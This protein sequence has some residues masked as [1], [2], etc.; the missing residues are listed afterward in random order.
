VQPSQPDAQHSRYRGLSTQAQLAPEGLDSLPYNFVPG[1]PA[2]SIA[3]SW[4]RGSPGS[5]T[6]RHAM[7]LRAGGKA[8]SKQ[9]WQQL[10]PAVTEFQNEF[11]AIAAAP[12]LVVLG[13][14]LPDMVASGVFTELQVRYILTVRPPLSRPSQ[15]D[16][17]LNATATPN[18]ARAADGGHRHSPASGTS[19]VVCARLA[20]RASTLVV[21]H[22]LRNTTHSTKRC[23]GRSGRS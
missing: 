2:L 10:P 14:T 19:T 12:P 9:Q 5:G 11:K 18:S 8:A 7:A 17:E 22:L 6:G 20:V 13:K 1:R 15:A 4:W 21:A 16:S 23:G 3:G